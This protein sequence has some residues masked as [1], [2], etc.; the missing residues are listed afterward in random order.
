[1][2]STKYFKLFLLFILIFK[3]FV[4]AQESHVDLYEVDPVGF[5]S[6]VIFAHIFVPL[7][8]IGV[9]FMLIRIYFR[10][11]LKRKSLSMALRV[12]F[13]LSILDFGFLVFQAITDGYL[14]INHTA[15]SGTTCKRYATVTVAFTL[16]HRLI[17]AG[18]SVITYLRVCR[19]KVCDT[20]RY[21]WKLFLPVAVL[22]IFIAVSAYDTYGPVIYWCAA[23]PNTIAIPISSICMTI[24][25]LS[26]CSF[27]YIQT[28]RAIRDIKKQQSSVAI[29]SGVVGNKSTTH[30]PI[31]SVEIKVSKKV[32]GYILVFILQWVPAIPYDICQFFGRAGAWVYCMVI[33]SINMG[34]I[35]NAIFYVM[36]EGWS[37]YGSEINTSAYDS[38][39]DK[40]STKVDSKNSTIPNYDDNM[41]FIDIENGSFDIEKN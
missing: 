40:S 2:L 30:S 13:Y 18:I 36:N 24:I 19:N 32:M 6:V 33:I 4:S 7:G 10:W 38:V 37:R 17:I 5:L 23:L 16:F 8:F 11:S 1:M 27:C 31:D 21:D 29:V 12:P 3:N 26:I 41:K 15:M 14:A 22:S 34:P 39:T 28:I 20:G 35:G 25:V 9:L